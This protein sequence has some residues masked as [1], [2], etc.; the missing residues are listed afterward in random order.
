MQLLDFP[1]AAQDAAAALERLRSTGQITPAEA[2]SITPEKL[3]A[4]FR[5]PLYQRIAA[6][7]TVARERKLFVRIGTLQLPGHE[8]L[9][10]RY[11]GTDGVLIG[12]MDLLF[13]EADGWVIVDYK[14][15]YAT[16]GA[17]LLRE[18]AL[19]LELYRAAAEHILGEPVKE[20]YLYSFTLDEVLKL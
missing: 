14:T 15:D 6:S 4:F 18:Y 19:Q 13:R 17:S 12:T 7:D 5:S 11:R 8:E 20:L 10:E 2:E 1:L 9:I 3:A 16:A